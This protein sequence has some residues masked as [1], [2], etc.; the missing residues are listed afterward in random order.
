VRERER[1]KERERER[2][3]EVQKRASDH[4]DLELEAIVGCPLHA[5]N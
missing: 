4:L 5:G 2:E 3:R 1:E